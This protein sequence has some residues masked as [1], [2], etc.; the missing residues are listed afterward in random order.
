MYNCSRPL[1]MPQSKEIW[2][3]NIILISTKIKYI[4][5]KIKDWSLVFSSRLMGTLQIRVW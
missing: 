4:V 5:K 2:S 3:L 1:V